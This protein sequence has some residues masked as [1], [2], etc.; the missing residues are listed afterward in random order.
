MLPAGDE[1]V[2]RI[3]ER[4]ALL[5]GHPYENIEPLQLVKNVDGQKVKG[6]APEP[7]A[8]A[9]HYDM[10]LSRHHS[11]HLTT[12][13]LTTPLTPPLTTPLTLPAPHNKQYEPH[14]DFGEARLPESTREYPRLPETARDCPR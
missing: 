9:A 13:S 14:F 7:A 8:A 12:P 1:V 2:K 11:H 4:A 6:G 3:T 5:T 10:A